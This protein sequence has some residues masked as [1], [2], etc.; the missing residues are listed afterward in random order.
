MNKATNK[1]QARKRT[2][3]VL[4]H[5]KRIGGAKAYMLITF[6]HPRIES[7]EEQKHNKSTHST[8]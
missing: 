2:N 1:E 7:T 8:K 6:W 5:E 3:L 4:M